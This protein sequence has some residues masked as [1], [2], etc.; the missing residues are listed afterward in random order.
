M[1][2]RCRREFPETDSRDAT[3]SQPSRSRRPPLTENR[4]ER[5]ALQ[6]REAVNLRGLQWLSSPQIHR[7]KRDTRD[8]M[9]TTE[10]AQLLRV[11]RNQK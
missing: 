10:G 2:T 5:L 11:F 4:E 9:H 3:V 8:G 6:R 7:E 1:S